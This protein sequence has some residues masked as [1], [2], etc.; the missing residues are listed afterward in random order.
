MAFGE[1]FLKGFFGTDYLKDYT[2]A[3]KTFRSNGYELAP[4][5]KF[6][7]HVYFNINTTD[8]PKLDDVF[9]STDRTTLSLTVKSVDLPRFE[10]DVDVKNQYNR[11]RLVQSRIQYN[12]VQVTFHDDG[13]D[14]VRN[15]WYN[16]YS[17]YYKDPSQSYWSASATNGTLG[18]SGNGLGDQK[19]SYNSRDI[20]DEER[21]VNDWGYVG[22]SYSDGTSGRL[23]NG[24]PPFFRDITIY[25]FNQHK[26]VSY[27]LINPLIS[28]WNHDTYDYAEGNGVMQ[29]T[30]TIQYET[31]K[32]Y[33]GAL[34]GQTPDPNVPGFADPAHYDTEKSPLARPGSTS[35]ILGQGG[36]VDAAGGIVK[37]LQSGSVAGIVGAIQKAGRTYGTFK[38]ADLQSVIREEGVG[39]VRD[40]IR[41]ELPGATR[42]AVNAADGFFFP[43]V[44]AQTNSTTDKP[45][46]PR[47]ASEDAVTEP[48]T[49]TTP[50]QRT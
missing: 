39:V 36:L 48:T 1:D 17:Y 3:S 32:Y 10:F 22:E 37:D 27:V 35:S 49:K 6:L 20:Y 30:M 33:N 9:T 11:K 44:P 8:I 26:F 12:P 38:D 43:K 5:Q 41:G 34:S 2:H 46:T 13:G 15:M 25:G 28:S 4:R 42:Q 19:L 45:A 31:V 50:S 7:F 23:T 16:Y 40:V 14:L 47:S 24:K 21:T 29:N 18:Q